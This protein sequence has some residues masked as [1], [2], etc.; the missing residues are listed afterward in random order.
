MRLTVKAVRSERRQSQKAGVNALVAVIDGTEYRLPSLCAN[1]PDYDKATKLGLKLNSDMFNYHVMRDENVRDL[2]SHTIS[3]FKKLTQMHNPT[4]TS[5]SF[6]RKIRGDELSR[7]EM[8]QLQKDLNTTFMSYPESD[9]KQ[10]VPGL[11]HD[12]EELESVNTNQIKCPTIDSKCPLSPFRQ[13]AEYIVNESNYKR[14]NVNWGNYMEIEKWVALSKIL[15]GKKKWCNMTGLY[16]RRTRTSKRFPKTT[17][18]IVQGLLCGV[19]TF[20]FSWPLTGKSDAY[21]F[22]AIDW[23]YNKTDDLG[24]EEATIR[25]FNSIQKEL[26]TVHERIGTLTFGEYCEKK[27]GLLMVASKL[28]KTDRHLVQ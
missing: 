16:P 20:C 28:M 21:L 22:D 5:M 23:Y 15:Y 13:K 2:K 8:L 9:L 26:Q 19:Q 17:S 11:K 7:S 10:D 14:F 6:D 25:S 3:E 1:N 18:N 12:L 4:V 27:E 24:Y